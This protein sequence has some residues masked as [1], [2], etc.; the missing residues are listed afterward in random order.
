ML[1]DANRRTAM[2]ADGLLVGGPAFQPH[3]K[4]SSG[5]LPQEPFACR[6]LNRAPGQP[7]MQGP[8][9]L[10]LPEP[11]MQMLGPVPIHPGWMDC[12]SFPATWVL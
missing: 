3:I 8:A 11:F 7:E 5:V 2:A 4:D 9:L 12:D 1:R 6:L 10:H